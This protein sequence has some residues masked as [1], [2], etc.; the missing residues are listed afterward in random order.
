MSA[1]RQVSGIAIA[2]PGEPRLRQ[3]NSIAICTLTT[4]VEELGAACDAV[5]MMPKHDLHLTLEEIGERRAGITTRIGDARRA[6]VRLIEC[7]K[8][9][10]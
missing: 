2:P 5:A 1:G 6:A 9:A 10:T 7:L 3:V 4:M 8:S